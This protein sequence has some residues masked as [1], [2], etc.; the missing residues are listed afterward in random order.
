MPLLMPSCAI[1]H[2]S[3]GVRSTPGL[4]PM[5][6][7]VRRPWF[8]LDAVFSFGGGH[9]TGCPVSALRPVPALPLPSP[10]ARAWKEGRGHPA[11]IVQ[12]HAAQR[13]IRASVVEL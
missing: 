13:R 1:C 6:P 8:C 2:F 10:A 5:V 11:E 7:P 12:Q 4:L 3:S 9:Y